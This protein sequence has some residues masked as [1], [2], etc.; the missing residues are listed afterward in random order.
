MCFSI[1]KIKRAA[2]FIEGNNSLIKHNELLNRDKTSI[3]FSDGNS[4]VRPL[5]QS[6]I[7]AFFFQVKDVDI[8]AP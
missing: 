2:I 1:L 7:S 8:L 4:R 5:C 3:L 6:K